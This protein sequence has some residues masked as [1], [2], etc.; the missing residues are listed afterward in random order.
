MKKVYIDGEHLSL[1]DVINVARH[2]Y[3]VAIDNSA[4][5]NIEN[6]RKVVEKFA[7]EEKVIYG[8]TTGFGELCVM[9]S[10]LAIKR[11]NY[12]EI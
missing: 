7:E 4:F 10:F 2:Y 5:E 12:K 11:K 6:S 1:E 9:F 3:D 8:V